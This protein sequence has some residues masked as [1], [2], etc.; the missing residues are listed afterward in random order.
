[1]VIQIDRPLEEDL[2]KDALIQGLSLQEYVLKVL[3]ER[4][5]LSRS[6]VSHTERMERLSRAAKPYGVSLSNEQTSREAIY[7]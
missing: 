6:K 1:M 7:D 2:K 5:S 3:N 4:S